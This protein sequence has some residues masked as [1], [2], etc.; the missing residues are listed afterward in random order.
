M[1]G[2]GWALVR[3]LGFWA[4]AG[5]NARNW[6]GVGQNTRILGWSLRSRV[7]T[8]ACQNIR[9][10]VGFGQDRWSLAS[11]D[12]STCPIFI[13]ICQASEAMWLQ[14]GIH[15]LADYR[16]WPAQGSIFPFRHPNT[17]TEGK[18]VLSDKSVCYILR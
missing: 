16:I 14:L 12:W 11:F 15:G 17:V 3:I 8:G 6:L 4:G 2:F 7:A 1:V 9:L 18:K 10:L 13:G 5:Q